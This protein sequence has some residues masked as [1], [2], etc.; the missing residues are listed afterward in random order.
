MRSFKY[1]V[2]F[3]K[4][5]SKLLMLNREKAPIMGVWNGVGGKI[6]RG[7]S[8]EEAALRE[9]EEETGIHLE[10]FFSQGTITWETS[11]GV[12]DGLHV[13]LGELDSSHVYETPKKMREGILDWKSID[14]ILDSQNLGIPEKIPHYLPVLLEKEGVHIFTYMDGKMTH[15]AN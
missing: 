7:E 9:V 14:W 12:I 15:E 8:P 1:T 5:G 11:E 4:Q 6:E 10:D 13:F 3:I 2:C